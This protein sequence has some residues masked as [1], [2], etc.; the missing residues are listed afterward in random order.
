M[1][2]MMERLATN[3]ESG[4]LEHPYYGYLDA[5]Q[6]F[7]IIGMHWKHHLQQIES[8]EKSSDTNL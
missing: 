8:L 4:K 3:P 2:V 1:N 5:A 7:Q 6:W